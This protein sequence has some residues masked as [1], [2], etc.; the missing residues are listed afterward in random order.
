MKTE[1]PGFASPGGNS[2]HRYQDSCLGSTSDTPFQFAFAG[3]GCG[4]TP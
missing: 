3:A 4:F 1:P 2:F